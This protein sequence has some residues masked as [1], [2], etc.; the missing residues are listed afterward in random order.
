M[1]PQQY[2]CLQPTKQYQYNTGIIN[3]PLWMSRLHTSVEK[4]IAFLE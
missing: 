2:T 1:M 4:Q 3:M